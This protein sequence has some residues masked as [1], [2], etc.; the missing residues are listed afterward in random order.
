MIF[1]SAFIIRVGMKSFKPYTSHVIK[2]DVEVTQLISVHYFEYTK[3]YKYHGE[4]HDFWE[5][6]YIDRGNAYVSCDGEEH[7]LSQGEII[8]LPPNLFHNIRA[9]ELRPSNVF[10]ASF[11]VQ[12]ELMT[13]L[14]NKVFM[15][16]SKMKGLIRSVIQEGELA[17]E[18]PMPN[19]Y[20][21]QEKKGRS[22]GSQQLMKMRLE[23]LIILLIRREM[24]HS[25]ESTAQVSSSKSRFDSQIAEAIMD[26]LQKHI[27]GNLSMEDITQLLGYGKTYL[28]TVF[29]KV[30]GTSIMSCYTGLKI[31]EAKYLIRENTASITEISEMLGFNT[32]QYFSKRF[33]QIVKMSPKQYENSVRETWSSSPNTGIE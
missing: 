16:S 17:F 13:R 10:I 8:F 2:M 6:M 30:Y 21:L 1:A 27:Y 18:L 14:G 31:N 25:S 23:E 11:V 29:K 32:P 19:R 12:S 5:I 4:S 3:D 24:K 7:L 15:L 33:S 22:F 9:D 20:C 26:L 28:S